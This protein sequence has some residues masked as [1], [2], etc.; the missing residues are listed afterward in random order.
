[1]PAAIAAIAGVNGRVIRGDGGMPTN[2]VVLDYMRLTRG[3]REHAR[4][5][6]W[7]GLSQVMVVLV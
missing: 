3:T 2:M 1:M 7:C 5:H 6:L 4:T